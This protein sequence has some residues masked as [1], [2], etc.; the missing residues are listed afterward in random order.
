MASTD[1][2][3]LLFLSFTGIIPRAFDTKP[4]EVSAQFRRKP[5]VWILHFYGALLH[6]K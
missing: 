5:L 4:K 2:G 3:G 1:P 6:T